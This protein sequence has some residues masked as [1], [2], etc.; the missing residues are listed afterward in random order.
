MPAQVALDHLA[1]RKRGVAG[2]LGQSAPAG[3]KR[4]GRG[5]G[6]LQ[7]LGHH[8]LQRRLVAAC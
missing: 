3:A 8:L 4:L 5:L 6:R 2:A 7:H 1:H